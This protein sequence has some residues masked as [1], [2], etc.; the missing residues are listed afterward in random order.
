MKLSFLDTKSVS[1]FTSTR[2]PS[3][4]VDEAGD[5]AFSVTRSGLACLGAE[6]DAQQ[7]FRLGHVAIGF[8]SGLLAFHHGGV[9]L[10]RSSAT[11][12][13]VIAAIF[14]PSVPYS[15]HVSKLLG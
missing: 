2:A 9:G 7:L 10:A 12:F 3:V 4:A 13:A 6:L 1:L 14:I 15:V 11:M 5:H 8:R